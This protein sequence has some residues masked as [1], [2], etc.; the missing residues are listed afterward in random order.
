MRVALS[1]LATFCGK[2]GDSSWPEMHKLAKTWDGCE[3]VRDRMR[4]QGRLLDWPSAATTGVATKATLKLNRFIIRYTMMV[5]VEVSD[6]PKSPPIAW[7]RQEALHTNTSNYVNACIP[8]KSPNYTITLYINPI[9]LI[10]A[11][12]NL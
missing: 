8:K 5:W 7:I 4:T 6:G 3:I 2:M 11:L 9:H 1:C 12:I 10:Y